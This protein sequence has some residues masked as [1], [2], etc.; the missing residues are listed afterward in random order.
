MHPLGRA[1]AAQ[2]P[3]A[4]ALLA[5]AA[6]LAVP[7]CGGP[8]KP[9]GQAKQGGGKRVGAATAPAG[10]VQQGLASWY[11]RLRRRGLV[12]PGPFGPSRCPFR[13]RGTLRRQTSRP[14]ARSSAST[15][16]SSPSDAVRN[17]RV[18]VTNQRNGRSVILRIN[19]RGPFGAGRI[20]DVTEAAAEQLGMKEA[21]V[22]PV[23][24]ERLP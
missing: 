19:D 5:I 14:V 6:L 21:G 10:A 9:G 2:A 7:A 3:I 16:S 8:A 24:V 23:K 4:A 13:A 11:G 1:S 22:V 12:A 17:T 18:R 20:I 15:M